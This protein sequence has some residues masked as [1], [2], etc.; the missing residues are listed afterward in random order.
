V[1]GLRRPSVGDGDRWRSPR[2]A[3]YYTPAGTVH[4]FVINN[5]IGFTTSDPRDSLRRCTAP[6]VVQMIEAPVLPRE[7]DDP[8]RSSCKAAALDY[9]QE[10][11]KD[12]WSTI[13]A[14]ELGH[15]EQRHA[16]ANPTADVQEDRA[17]HPGT[18]KLSARDGRSKA[19]AAGGPTICQGPARR[20]GRPARNV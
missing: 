11:N 7:G 18:R 6:D 8:E 3:G 14:S 19:A 2:R 15:N 1:T 20:D 4:R 10:F 5:Q 13:A 12:S 16:S 17:Q 9:R